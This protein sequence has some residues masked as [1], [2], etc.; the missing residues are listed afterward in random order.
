MY[1]MAEKREEF[2]G[3]KRCDKWLS[4]KGKNKSGWRRGLRRTR[5]CS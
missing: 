1:S 4:G 2:G 3:A 5:P